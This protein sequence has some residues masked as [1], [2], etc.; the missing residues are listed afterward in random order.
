MPGATA[1]G[2]RSALGTTAPDLT[3]PPGHGLDT[4]RGR[5]AV[6]FGAPA[7]PEVMREDGGVRLSF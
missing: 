3:A 6:V 1:T 2:W 4:L 5:L 7:V